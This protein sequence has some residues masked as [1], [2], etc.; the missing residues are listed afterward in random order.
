MAGGWLAFLVLTIAGERQEMS[1]LTKDARHQCAEYQAW[2]EAW[3]S[4]RLEGE[5]RPFALPQDL[6][7]ARLATVM[8]WLLTGVHLGLDVVIALTMLINPLVLIGVSLV[9]IFGVKSALLLLLDDRLR[10]QLTKRRLQR[11]VMWPALVLVLLS[12]ILLVGGRT[13]FGLLALWLAGLLNLALCGL[14]LGCMGLAT[15]LFCL[16]YLYNRSAHAER[17]Y[18]K[19]EQEALATLRV[20]E[21][22][23]QVEQDLRPRPALN[24]PAPVRTQPPAPEA[25]ARQQQSAPP[26]QSVAFVPLNDPA[27]KRAQALTRNGHGYLSVLLPLVLLGVSGL[28]GCGTGVLDPQPVTTAAVA[29][30]PRAKTIRVFVDWSL[31][32]TDQGL[33]EG[34][35]AVAKAMPTLAAELRAEQVTVHQFGDNGWEAREVLAV[36]LPALEIGQASEAERIFGKLGEAR[37]TAVEAAYQQQMAERLKKLSVESLLPPAGLPEPRCTDVQ[38]VLRRIG[39]GDSGTPELAVLLTDLHENCT[40]RL[41]PVE[42]H[43]AALVVLLLPE[44]TTE[45]GQASVQFEQRRAEAVRVYPGAVVIPPFGDLPQAVRAALAK[46]ARRVE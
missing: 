27:V 7:D 24:T 25:E 4:R 12:A 22:A 30:A 8:G 40:A 6:R 34:A 1:R 45:A 2:C 18:R 33:T 41:Q 36:G 14:S 46:Q 31:S 39:R 15:G 13:A 5:V 26:R 16:A 11:W 9:L 37:T 43:N 28:S 42:T 17:R 21:L 38:G 3:L 23:E 10:P 20:L 44:K 19:T 29:Q 32:G 35:R